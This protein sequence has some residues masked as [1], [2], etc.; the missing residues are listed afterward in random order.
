MQ[1]NENTPW[2][3][4]PDNGSAS[5]EAPADSDSEAAG[6]SERA[7]KNVTW[8][9]VEYLEHRHGSGWYGSLAL[10]TALLATIV[11]L[12]S[13]D[14]FATVIIVVVGG[15]VWVYAGQ[16]PGQAKYEITSS[17]VSVNGKLYGYG[18]YK[19]FTVVREGDLSSVNLFPLKR[20]LPPLSA[21][22]DPKDEQKIVEAIGS[23]L[24]YENRKLDSIDR[25][26]RRLRL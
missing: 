24:P 13:K 20:L 18:N 6:P 2:Q 10:A 9:A 25:L 26:T 16:K 22:F 14:I 4:K 23:Y 7:A 5:S 3:Y 19:S 15:I 11:Y 1:Q 8:E 12:V 21:Y 17:G